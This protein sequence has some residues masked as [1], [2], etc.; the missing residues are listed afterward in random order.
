MPMH[1]LP[2]RRWLQFRLTTWFVLVGIL[3]WAMF[4]WPYYDNL[5][6]TSDMLNDA[7]QGMHQ[8]D[9]PT[10]AG[11]HEPFSG[12]WGL[13][14]YRWF[15]T[16]KRSLQELVAPAVVLA[17]FLVAKAAW[18][19]ANNLAMR[20]GADPPKGQTS[21]TRSSTAE[22]RHRCGR[23]GMRRLLA[24]MTLVAISLGAARVPYG[25]AARDRSYANY[26]YPYEDIAGLLTIASTTALGAAI[27]LLSEQGRESTFIGF[28]V[29]LALAAMVR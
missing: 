2:P 20:S 22:S 26:Y 18:R 15:W 25:M 28:I 3:A 11:S 10:P 16:L 8:S 7:V 17:A 19:L 12:Y 4:Q 27:G 9:D 29:G 13:D 1:L 6:I 24:S 21:E 23:F 14:R 5:D